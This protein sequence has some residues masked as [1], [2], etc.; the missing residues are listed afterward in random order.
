MTL[1]PLV[2]AV[3][4]LNADDLAR[5]SRQLV[6]PE[7]GVTGQRR[8]AAAKV[9]VVGAGGLGS[10]VLLYLAAAGVGTIGVVDSDRVERSNLHRQVIHTDAS[11]GLPKVMS[12][13][14]TLRAQHP[15]I[16]VQPHELRLNADN[17]DALIA[18]YDLVIDGADNFPTRYLVNDTCVRFGKPLVWG[19]VLGFAAQ[20]SVFWDAAP[21]GRGIELRDVFPEPPAAGTVPSCAEAGVV[22][23]VCAQ[24]GS[25]MAMEAIKLIT[26]LG[27]SLLGRVLVLDALAG[28]FDEVPVRRSGRAPARARPEA[29]ADSSSGWS[30]GPEACTPATT[31][32]PRTLQLADGGGAVLLDVRNPDEFATERI[33]GSVNLPLPALLDGSG[34]LRLSGSGPSLPTDEPILVICRS[35]ARAEIAAASLTA[36]GYSQVHVLE[37]GLL[38]LSAS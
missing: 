13:A 28:R 9:L 24:A 18:G 10:P 7:L 1:P 31:A 37:G 14:R 17:A 5:Y 26:G 20:V 11:V 34:P 3:G 29:A 15:S 16:T 32:A 25:V 27:R 22:G 23:A 21:D 8:L 6:L 35:G 30:P 36:R 33:S 2:P 19:S 4:V 38:A 12:A